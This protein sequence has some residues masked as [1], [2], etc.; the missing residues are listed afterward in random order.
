MTRLPHT[1]SHALPLLPFLSVHFLTT[2]TTSLIYLYNSPNCTITTNINTIMTI[3]A[4]ISC[5]PQS[6]G[7]ISIG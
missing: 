3:Q 6:N 2:T 1:T 5:R 4:G 7:S